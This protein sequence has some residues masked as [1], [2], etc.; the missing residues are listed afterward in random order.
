MDPSLI[1]FWNVRG[2]NSA[3]R[4][5]VVRSLVDS[6]RVD[7]VCLQETKLVNCDC[8]TVLSML[9]ADFDNNLICL[10]SVGASGGVLITWRAK[11]GRIVASRVDSFSVSVKFNPADGVAWWLI[12][13]YGP[14]GHDRKIVFIHELRAIRAA[15]TGPWRLG[16]I[17]ISFSET[18][19]KTT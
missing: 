10:P 3:A 4:Q 9:G 5:D 6:L 2:L 7:V 16:V 14:Q 13:V 18:K 12:C 17:S 19:T 8:R 1:L 11:L 15:C